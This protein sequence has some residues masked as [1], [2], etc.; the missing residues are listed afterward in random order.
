MWAKSAYV[1]LVLFWGFV[2][3]LLGRG[4]DKNGTGCVCLR[5][6]E[7]ETEDSE[8]ELEWDWIEKEQRREKKLSQR[9]ERAP[10]R[11]EEK[12]GEYKRGAC[13]SIKA[14]RA[15]SVN[16]KKIYIYVKSLEYF[17][18]FPSFKKIRWN[19]QTE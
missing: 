10:S 3:L 2:F 1:H 8:T 16:K 17:P 18:F 4:M 6:R 12:K 7:S 13:R 19:H 15:T 11:E 9:K 14:E 5:K